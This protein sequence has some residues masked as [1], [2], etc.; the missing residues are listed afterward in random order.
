MTNGSNV[1]F[2]VQNAGLD[3]FSLSASG[4]LAINPQN[5][6]GNSVVITS[7]TASTT[8]KVVNTGGGTALKVVGN[9]VLQSATSGIPV[10]LSAAGGEINIGAPGDVINL[11]VDGVIYNFKENVR[12]NVLTAYLSQ[13]TSADSIW[14]SGNNSWS[15]P[16][17][18]TIK[19]IKVQYQCIE[20]GLALSLKNSNGDTITTINGYD[21]GGFSSVSEDLDY[22]LSSEEGLYVDINSAG[23][24]ITNLTVTVEFVYENR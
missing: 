13:P 1:L 2:T 16:E 17:D 6:T 12:R 24:G 4:T 10:V 11:N 18:I 23:E 20:G 19:A 9:L 5:T 22:F 21:C 8:L 7:P 14:G 15:P 3:L